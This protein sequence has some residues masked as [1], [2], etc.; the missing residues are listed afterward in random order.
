MTNVIIHL[1]PGKDKPIRMGH[2]WVFSG[3]IAQVE[4]AGADGALCSV[5][6]ASG[7]V[8]GTGCFNGRSAIRVRMLA[9]RDEP[10]D[11]RVL[12]GRIEE[13]VARRAA[14][15]DAGTDSWRL[16]NSEGDPLPG[17]IVDKYA[18]GVCMQI[19]TAGMEQFR[20]A[21]VDGLCR[22]CAPAFVYERSDTNAR[23]RE[24][25][26]PQEGLVAGQMPPEIIV[27][28]HKLAFAADLVAGQKTGFFFDQRENRKLF[29]AYAGGKTVCDCFCYSGGFSVSALVG[30][31]RSVLMVD[32]SEAAIRSAGH[33]C[34]RNGFE[35]GKRETATA[36]VFRFLREID[37]RFGCVVLDPPKFARHRGEVEAAARGY[38]DINLLAFKNVERGGFVFTFSC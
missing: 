4:G 6:S 14:I 32:S 3:A 5:R 36:D 18:G 24:G 28:E 37:R 29:G 10:F 13:A 12:A 8:L 1:K 20:D 33:N 17:L 31:A 22:S 35:P 9:G 7:K 25:L 30:G 26:P 15:L 21:V 2:P 19:L 34:L 23:T 38:K 16:V 27:T 11:A